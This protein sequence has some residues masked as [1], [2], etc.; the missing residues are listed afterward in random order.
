MDL[1]SKEGIDKFISENLKD[2]LDGINETYSPI[3]IEELINRIKFTITEFNDE[4]SSVFEE[5]KEKEKKR[6]KMYMMIKSGNIPT[7]NTDK[8]SVSNEWEKEID[9][10]ED[11]EKDLEKRAPVVTIMGH[12]DHGKTSI[13]DAF[14]N[15]NVV[16]GEAGGIT[17]HI[18]AY[19]TNK[20]DKKITFIDTPG[21]EAFSKMRARGS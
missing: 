18:G 11:N 2:V 21:H 6:Q 8:D 5:L 20:N 3:L 1:T 10:I 13:L 16:S 15:S 4:M 12:V 9:E 17:Q 7:K 14:R 19:Q